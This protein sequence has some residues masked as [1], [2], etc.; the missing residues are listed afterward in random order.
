MRPPLGGPD[1]LHWYWSMSL[2]IVVVNRVTKTKIVWYYFMVNKM[3]FIPHHFFVYSQCTMPVI[4]IIGTIGI[5]HRH[6]IISFL[7]DKDMKRNL[8]RIIFGGISSADFTAFK[9]S[10]DI[11]TLDVLWP[12]L[13]LLCQGMSKDSSL[14]ELNSSSQDTEATVK[15]NN[16]GHM[17][18]TLTEMQQ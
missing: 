11:T 3:V 10:L 7:H 17:K 18:G 2:A 13:P 16:L 9:M 5:H 8:I 12:V 4:T 1:I 14:P 15:N 6:S